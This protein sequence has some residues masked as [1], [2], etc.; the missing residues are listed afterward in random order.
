[1]IRSRPPKGRRAADVKKINPYAKDPVTGRLNYMA[2]RPHL[3]D[4][5]LL[6]F[7]PRGLQAHWR[8]LKDG[9]SDH[10]G[11]VARWGERIMVFEECASGVVARPLSG[12]LETYAGTVELFKP[13]PQLKLTGEQRSRAR[14]EL[15]A[16]LSA[17]PDWR[18][19][20][21][22]AADGVDLTLAVYGS[23]LVTLVPPAL[24][25]DN[26]LTAAQALARAPQLA[27]VGL[28]K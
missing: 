18:Q 3:L 27:R 26:K 10:L 24:A 5:D 19:W 23:A 1:M 20:L 9:A 17:K 16:R 14:D 22:P 21:S 13:Q 7:R 8:K 6:L 12:R 15:L 2:L 28:L 11:L 25:D 4:G